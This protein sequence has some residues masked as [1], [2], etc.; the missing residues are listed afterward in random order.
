MHNVDASFGLLFQSGLPIEKNLSAAICLGPTQDEEIEAVVFDIF[1][2][3]M[4]AKERGYNYKHTFIVVSS[5]CLKAVDETIR[6][7]YQQF[8]VELIPVKS[9]DHLLKEGLAAIS[10]LP[11]FK[12]DP[13]QKYTIFQNSK[14]LIAEEEIKEALE[15]HQFCGFTHILLP[16]H[17]QLEIEKLATQWDNDRDLANH[18]GTEE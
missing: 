18:I 1:Y 17:L 6:Q 8:I 10:C 11:P 5:D 9:K 14:A 3:L 12:D 4:E 13:L 7:V 15:T 16:D 2:Q